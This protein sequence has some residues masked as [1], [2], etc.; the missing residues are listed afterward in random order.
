MFEH[1]FLTDKDHPNYTFQPS[2]LQRK[3]HSRCWK[4]PLVKTKY[5]AGPH[6]PPLAHVDVHSVTFCPTL[7]HQ[8]LSPTDNHLK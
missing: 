6:T 1:G 4:S 7:L 2:T 5:T 3:V 8:N